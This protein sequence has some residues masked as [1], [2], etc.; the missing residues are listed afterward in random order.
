MKNLQKMIILMMMTDFNN[1]DDT[2][3]PGRRIRLLSVRTT[4]PGLTS[5]EATNRLQYHR[6]VSN[7]YHDQ[8]WFV[9]VF[10]WS[11]FDK[12]IRMNF[13]SRFSISDYVGQY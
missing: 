6:A 1:Y 10:N 13:S 9:T 3:M 5:R 12:K 11:S 2:W 7:Q 8:G 4:S